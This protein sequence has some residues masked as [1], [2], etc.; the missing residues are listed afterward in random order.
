MNEKTY[1]TIAGAGAG[2]IVLGIIVIVTGVAAGVLMIVNGGR[3]LKEK[4]KVLF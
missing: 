3:L 2:N 4:S 1:K